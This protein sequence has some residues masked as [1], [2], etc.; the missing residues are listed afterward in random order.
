[1]LRGW[2]PRGVF[3]PEG[4]SGIDAQRIALAVYRGTLASTIKLDYFFEEMLCFLVNV[5]KI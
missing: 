1:M 4:S 2:N 3:S 5:R